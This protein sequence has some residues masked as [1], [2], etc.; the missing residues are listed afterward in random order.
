MDKENKII[1][2]TQHLPKAT[3]TTA[4]GKT[5]HDETKLFTSYWSSRESQRKE[6]RHHSCPDCS[7]IAAADDQSVIIR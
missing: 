7:S 4:M 5:K 1:L 6:K 2:P 3:L